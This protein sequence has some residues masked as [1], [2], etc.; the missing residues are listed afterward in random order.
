M[1]FRF[2]RRKDDPQLALLGADGTEGQRLS[3]D[4]DGADPEGQQQ[5][6]GSGDEDPAEA[7]RKLRDEIGMVCDQAPTA[8]GVEVFECGADVQT[9]EQRLSAAHAASAAI[10]L[11]TFGAVSYTHLTLPTTPY[12]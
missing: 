2:E 3:D 4:E 9:L 6:D 11:Q 8:D 1:I 12:V 10:D 5:S 7:A